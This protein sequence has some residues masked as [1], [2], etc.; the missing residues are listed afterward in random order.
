MARFEKKVW[1]KIQGKV[2]RMIWGWVQEIVHGM[3]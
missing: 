1:E 2:E 3:V